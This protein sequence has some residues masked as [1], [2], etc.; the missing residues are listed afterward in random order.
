M[1]GVPRDMKC[2]IF[3]I[4]RQR[5]NFESIKGVAGKDLTNDVYARDGETDTFWFIGKVARVSGEYLLQ[6]V[7]LHWEIIIADTC[8]FSGILNCS[9]VPI[10]KSMARQW[11]MIEEHA[12]RLRPNELYPKWG[13]IQLWVAPGDSEV[14]VQ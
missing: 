11:P 1:V 6:H 4:N 10:E 8:L 2:N 9:D 7:F 13:S 12:A 5:E 3:N 14:D